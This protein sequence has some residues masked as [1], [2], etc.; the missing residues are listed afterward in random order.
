MQERKNIVAGNWKMNL[1]YNT[2]ITL[3]ESILASEL[4]ISKNQEI[5]LGVPSIL[6]AKASELTNNQANIH[7]AA[8]DCHHEA[9]GA[10]TG[11]ISAE[12]VSSTGAKYVILGHSERRMYHQEDSNILNQKIKQAFEYGLKIIYCVG[13]PLEVREK[14]QENE[15]ISTQLNETIFQLPKNDMENIII[16]YEPIWAI[17]TGKTASPEQAQTMHEHIRSEVAKA[18]DE[19][20]AATT[21]I[22]Y[23]GS[24]NASNA[25][26]LFALKDVDGGLI[27]GASLKAN[28]FKAI[29]ESI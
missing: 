13:E 19:N 5:I 23:G 4:N 29:I 28:D 8:Q 21:L 16:A 14:N 25:K 24:C 26:E 2:G 10:F 7:I 11:N 9:S 18:F 6:L 1:N 22:L 12:M 15:Y 20:T 27:G 3:I 17:G